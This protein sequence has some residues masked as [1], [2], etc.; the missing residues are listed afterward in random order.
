MAFSRA[1]ADASR[2]ALDHA[3]RD[4]PAYAPWRACDPG[5]D[6]DIDRRYRAMPMLTKA[7]LRQASPRSFAPRTHDLQAGIA[8]GAVEL[9]H[10]SGTTDERVTNVWHQPWWDA[11]E[12]ASWQLNAHTARL[13]LGAHREALLTSARS[14]G[15]LDD[16][17]DLAMAERRDGRF[18]FLNEKSAPTLWTPALCRRMLDE[19]AEF[20]P[21][22]LEANPSY[23]ARLARFA[24]AHQVH[25]WQP[26]LI[27]LTFEL[28]TH[29]A[30]AA[31]RRVFSA[32]LISSYGTTETG[33]VFMQCEHG[34][35]HH[36]T[37]FC[38]VDFLPCSSAHGG[39]LLGRMLVTPFH[40]PWC[41]YVR[42][43]VG[44]L[45]RLR[46]DGHCPCG[47]T[48]GFIAAAIEGRI[49]NLTTT[50][51]GRAVTEAR[52]D[53]AMAGCPGVFD[54]QLQ[55]S[56]PGMYAIAIVAEADAPADV[57]GPVERALRDVYGAGAQVSVTLVDEL[58]PSASGKFRRAAAA[59]AFAA[60]ELFID[61]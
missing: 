56:A 5:G 22:V 28:P 18:L 16:T 3:L 49:K 37:A 30:R 43:D 25:V 17:R 10:T 31:I 51:A 26:P 39:P 24:A 57:R 42:F 33:Y 52:L 40:N 14:V 34:C 6:A 58:A 41:Q 55:Q 12:R 15:V 50:T 8:S 59:H 47:R 19:L 54:Y 11:S 2:A 36:N 35:F 27:I 38:R 1:Y 45:I 53:A 32:P 60:E 4:I 7:D 9:V 29:A 61:L 13:S 44:D 21:L 20:Q 23:L 48:H 46:P